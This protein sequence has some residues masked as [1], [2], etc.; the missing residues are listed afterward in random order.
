MK[1]LMTKILNL[2]GVIVEERLET[3]K[4]IILSVIVTN[5]TAVC[6]RCGQTSRRRD[7]NKTHSVRDLPITNREVILKV[8]RRQFK[9]K[10]CKKPF[11]EILDFVELRKNFTQR[12]AQSITEQVI[13]SDINNVARNNKLTAEQI[14]SMVMAAAKSVMKFELAQLCRLG[15]DEISWR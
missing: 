12:Y 2:P 15:I 4:T 5:K 3:K 7:Q 6:P 8:N 1:I 9:C 13:N 10:D 11:S 14:E